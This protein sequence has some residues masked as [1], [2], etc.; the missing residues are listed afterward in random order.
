MKLIDFFTRLAD[1]VLNENHKELQ[2]LYEI[3]SKDDF[4]VMAENGCQLSAVM[5]DDDKCETIEL[6]RIVM[7][8]L[9]N[10]EQR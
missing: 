8:I 6:H 4:T 7:N 10:L 1:A 5:N 3:S 2:A 9:E